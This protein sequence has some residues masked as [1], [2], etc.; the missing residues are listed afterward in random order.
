MRTVAVLA[1]VALL[2]ACG[3]TVQ[4]ERTVQVPGL[5]GASATADPLGAGPAG[6]LTS[7][8]SAGGSGP[9]GPSGSG[10]AGAPRTSQGVPSATAPTGTVA[11]APTSTSTST[12]AVQRITT[13]IQVG[14]MTTTVGNAQGAGLNTGQSYSD[15]Q[16]YDALVKGY[17]AAGGLAGRRIVATYGATDTAS[18][19]WST[20]FQAACQNLTQDHHVQAV[21]GYVFV[22]LDSFEQCLSSKGVP[23]LYAG[24]QPGDAG[25]QRDFP[26]L[27][28]T[29]HPTVDVTSETVL[30]GAI[31]SGR[32]TPR[33]K[34]GIV[35]DGCSHGERAF[36]SSTVPYLK[37]NGIQ[38]ESVSIGC[39]GGSTDVG[40][41]LSALKSA[42]LR[43]AADHVDVVMV[44]N[45]VA[46]IFF[47]Q[48]AQ[49][50]GYSPTYINQG[51]GGAL[52]AQGGA[53]PQSQLKNLHGFGWTPAIDVGPSHQPYART[54]S[55]A[56]CLAKLSSQGMTPTK[57]N[58]FMIAYATCD[59]LDL[60]AAALSRT[61]GRTGAAEVRQALVQLMPDFHG[62]LT[63][64]GAHAV[65]ASER[66]GPGHYRE[67]G[68]TDSCSCFTYRGPVRLVPQP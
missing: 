42:Q 8:P 58:D 25:A 2:A 51:S 49:S 57:F 66:G 32:L 47:M 24:Y 41:A 35:V 44:L 56:A 13:P 6:P 33:S 40:P 60:Y 9:V 53:A 29:A 10:P 46:L 16:F 67:S 59:S 5:S 21:L 23:H 18:S 64:D 26:N 62:S 68:W 1:S 31:A 50:Q 43:F 36:A 3:S 22:F 37:R 4:A 15:N 34:L 52:E 61:G 27:V 14:F 11:S 28:S 65:S 38:Y 39:S 63:Y 54:P 45:T 30:A 19:D 7:S 55:Q 17:N 48:D 20:Q 12:A